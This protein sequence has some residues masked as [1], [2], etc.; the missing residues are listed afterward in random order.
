MSATCMNCNE[1]EQEIETLTTQRDAL[2]EAG[3]E[4]LRMYQEVQPA[5]GW[6]GVEEELIDAIAM[7]EKPE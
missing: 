1:Y 6:E 7:V 4:A 3:K 2:L 5:G